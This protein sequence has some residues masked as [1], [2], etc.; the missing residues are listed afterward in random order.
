M[1]ILRPDGV[2]FGN[3]YGYSST[4][5]L[6][7]S[8]WFHYRW[9]ESGGTSFSTSWVVGQTTGTM[10][11]PARAKIFVYTNTPLRGDTDNWGGHYEDLQ[12]SVNGGSWTS[13]GRSG[14]V[15]RMM[16][17]NSPITNHSDFCVM[18]FGSI[19]SDFTLAL[20]TVHLRYDGDGAVN[21]SCGI[22]GGDDNTTYDANNQNVSCWKQM[23]VMGYGQGPSS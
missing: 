12:Y 2:Q 6:Q 23:I 17:A 19:A 14:F 21:T 11:L 10:N 4:E 7:T 8:G 16:T 13:V 18:D 1:S 5:N 15:S 3:G 9:S 22:G 20:R